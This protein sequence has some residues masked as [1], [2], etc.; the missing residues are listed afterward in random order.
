[1]KI[2]FIGLGAM[3][4]P[5]ARHLAKSH[6]V[7]VWNRTREVAEKHTRE[8]GTRLAG[9]LEECAAADV[10]ITIVPT[11]VEVD[12]IVDRLAGAVKEGTLWIDATSGDPVTSRETARRL[13]QQGIAF[14]D[15]P[16]TGGTPG[17]EAGALTVMVGG[18]KK[19]FE[20]AEPVIR[21]FAKK[22]VHVGE[23]GAGHA[24]KAIN[25]ALLA[26]NMLIA[27]ECFLMAKKFGI[28]L[29]RVF[30]V[31]NAGSGRSN[32]SENL[33]P[34]RLV[35]GQWPVTFKLGLHDKDVRIAE[36]MAHAQHM[37]APVLALTTSLF[38]AALHNLGKDADYLEVVKYIAEMN[39]ETW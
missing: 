7:T 38:S 16:V 10:I 11:S 26:T 13:S 39:G 2:S 25:N 36:S 6:D 20:R 14:V 32:V 18:S 3:G 1:M 23:V 27:G 34:S 19:D 8:A 31:I 28:D 12:E 35:D 5:M 33:L 22:I 37:A 21:T 24:V 30:E 4:Y 29:G 15:A 17:A 9:D